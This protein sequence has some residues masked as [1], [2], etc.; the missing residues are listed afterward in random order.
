MEGGGKAD[1]VLRF[2]LAT[3]LLKQGRRRALP[4]AGG[5]R[6]DG[7]GSWTEPAA[8]IPAFEALAASTGIQETSS[9]SQNASLSV[10]KGMEQ[11]DDD[12]LECLVFSSVDK[13]R[14]SWRRSLSEGG[15]DVDEDAFR[16]EADKLRAVAEGCM[17]LDGVLRLLMEI[18]RDAD[19][20][21][22]TADAAIISHSEY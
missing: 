3:W 12:D 22:D 2:A 13:L 5:G 19:A 10:A 9:I 15:G 18:L 4:I 17:A 21:G 7:I 14:A 6:S 8:V 16:R 20:N 1:V 11:G